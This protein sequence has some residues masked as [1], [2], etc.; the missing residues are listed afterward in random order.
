[1]PG[2]GM[3]IK[4]T[5]MENKQSFTLSLDFEGQHYEGMV[6]PSEERGKDG[7]PVFFRITLGDTFFAYFCCTDNGF[8][9]HEG[10]SQPKELVQAIEKYI[11][12]YYA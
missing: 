8:M 5:D 4:T 10:V 3:L 11:L 9:H 7:M 1:M 6:T 12:E 2:I